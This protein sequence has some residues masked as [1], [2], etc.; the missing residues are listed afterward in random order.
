V[1]TEVV[2]PGKLLT[3][4]ASEWLLA[5]RNEAS[6]IMINNNHTY[7]AE[8]RQRAKC[9]M[10]APVC[11]LTWRARCSL[12]EKDMVQP[13][14]PVHWNDF[15]LLDLIGTADSSSGPGN[16]SCPAGA[17]RVEGP[18]TFIVDCGS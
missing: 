8:V 9:N 7:C 18:A 11:F 6:N 16:D 13:S 5:C 3:A 17:A 4:T 10:N 2:K 1:L 12:R 15:P 14:Y